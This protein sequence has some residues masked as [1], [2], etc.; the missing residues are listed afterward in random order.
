MNLLSWTL[1]VFVCVCSVR[2]ANEINEITSSLLV[3]H[4]HPYATGGYFVNFVANSARSRSP[5]VPR[6]LRNKRNNLF[7][8]RY[9]VFV[10]VSSAN[11]RWIGRPPVWG[12][13][14]LTQCTSL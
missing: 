9:L 5:S 13:G 12:E 10:P 6:K 7:L 1:C 4:P 2:I 14:S 3:G 11:Q 8:I